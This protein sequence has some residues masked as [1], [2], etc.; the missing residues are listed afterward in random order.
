MLA[1]LLYL[2]NLLHLCS[3][4][5]FIVRSLWLEHFLRTLIIQIEQILTVN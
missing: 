3:F 4:H 1:R 5:L 2:F